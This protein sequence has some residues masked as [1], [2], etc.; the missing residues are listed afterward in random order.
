MWAPYI[1]HINKLMK[2]FKKNLKF[3]KFKN[4]KKTKGLGFINGPQD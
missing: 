2:F 3:I 1:C 4:E